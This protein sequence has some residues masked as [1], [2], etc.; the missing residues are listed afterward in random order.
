[1]FHSQSFIPFFILA[2]PAICRETLTI[3]ILMRSR[4]TTG[5]SCGLCKDNGETTNHSLNH[6]DMAKKL[7]NLILAIFGL[8]W[9]FGTWFPYVYLHVY[10]R[11]VSEECFV[12]KSCYIKD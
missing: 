1:M 4:G 3:D 5:N 7:R 2:W 9:V 11:S 6:C 8:K 10:G 12:Q